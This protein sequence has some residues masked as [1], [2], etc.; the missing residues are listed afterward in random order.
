M[1]PVG[2]VPLSK[3]RSVVSDLLVEALVAK[4]LAACV[5]APMMQINDLNYYE[6]LTPEKVDT[7]LDRLE[8]EEANNG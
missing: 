1:V 3:R 4:T 2:L 7:I 8:K 6:K 5:G